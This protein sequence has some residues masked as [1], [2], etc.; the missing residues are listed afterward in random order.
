MLNRKLRA[1]EKQAYNRV[2]KR[3]K[4]KKYKCLYEGCKNSA[5]GSHSQQRN[6]PLR[7]ISEKGKVYRL[8]DNLQKTLSVESGELEFHFSLK[9][10]GESSI[11]TGFCET[12]ENIFSVFEDRY[13]EKGNNHQ[14]CALFYR[15]FGYEKA[16]KRREHFRWTELQ[17]ELDG[18]YPRGNLMRLTPVIQSFQ[19][20]IVNSCDYHLTEAREMLESS[21]FEEL[22]TEWL[23]FEKN[24][25]VSCSSTVNLHLDNYISYTYANPGKPIPSFTFNL[26]PSSSSTIVLFSWLKEFDAEAEWLVQS[27]NESENIEILLNR[28]AFCDSEDTCVNPLLWESIENPQNVIENMKHVSDRGPLKESEIPRIIKISEFSRG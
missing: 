27:L 9:G 25:N 26:I 18:I 20:H 22:R 13:I 5:I 6:G 4:N 24:L 3:I 14:A 12:H 11:F 19:N 17:V 15:T 23:V 1:A 8:N 2:E 7:A 28:L 10:I 21:S 16:R